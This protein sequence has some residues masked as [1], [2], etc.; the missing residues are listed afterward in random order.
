MLKAFN[1][2]VMFNYAADYRT[3]CTAAVPDMTHRAL[4]W[5]LYNYLFLLIYL[6]RMYFSAPARWQNTPGS[7]FN[8]R[9]SSRASKATPTLLLSALIFN[10][11]E[12]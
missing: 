8:I 12:R 6:R 4:A 10:L 11:R 9:R 1:P 5:A 7:A 3:I 2:V